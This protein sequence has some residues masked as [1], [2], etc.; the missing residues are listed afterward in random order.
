M[1]IINDNGNDNNN[2][3]DNNNKFLL[4]RQH[5]QPMT[6]CK[7]IVDTCELPTFYYPAKLVSMPT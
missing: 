7:L 1:M 3:D 6:L 4:T 2:N 5:T